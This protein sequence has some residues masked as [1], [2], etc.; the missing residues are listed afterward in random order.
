MTFVCFFLIKRELYFFFFFFSSRRRH[1]TLTCDGSSDVCSSD[2]ARLA[3]ARGAGAGTQDRDGERGIG[4]DHLEE[5]AGIRRR[6]GDCAKHL[7][8]R[9]A[10]RG[11]G[12]ERLERGE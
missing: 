9:P 2:L 8:A 12:L 11:E 1:T 6:R 5:P 3:P 10:Q 7:L 4:L